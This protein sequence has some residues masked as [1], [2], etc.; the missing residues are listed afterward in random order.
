MWYVSMLAH[1][2]PRCS[3]GNRASTQTLNTGTSITSAPDR[4]TPPGR[5]M[6]CSQN[7]RSTSRPG[8]TQMVASVNLVVLRSNPANPKALARFARNSRMFTE[9]SFYPSRLFVPDTILNLEATILGTLY[10]T[11]LSRH[12]EERSDEA[13]HLRTVT[14]GGWIASLRSQS[15]CGIGGYSKPTR[16]HFQPCDRHR[17]NHLPRR[18][19]PPLGISL[20]RRRPHL[21]DHAHWPAPGR[22]GSSSASRGRD[23]GG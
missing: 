12:C 20:A 5:R 16:L 13:I 3:C 7:A 10:L 2:T 4:M 8:N 11:R 23:D 19:F 15:R 14:P 9:T 6:A 1:M 17:L 18:H 22:A 21:M